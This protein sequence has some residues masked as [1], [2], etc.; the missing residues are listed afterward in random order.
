MGGSVDRQEL[1]SRSGRRG[2][3]AAGA[4]IAVIAVL[5]SGLAAPAW[6]ADDSLPGFVATAE[7][8]GGSVQYGMPGFVVVEQFI[9]GGGPAAKAT[10]SDGVSRSFASNPYPGDNAIGAPGLASL[11]L[12]SAP[13]GYPLYVSAQNPTQPSQAL[14][15]PAGLYSLSAAAKETESAG[16][17]RN[18]SPAADGPTSGTISEAHVTAEGGKIVATAVSFARGIVVGPL[19]VASVESK[20]TTVY[21]S[22]ADKPESTGS[23]VLEGGKVG[24]FTFSFD[25]RGLKVA[26]NGVPLPSGEGLASLNK[27]LAPSGFALSFDSAAPGADGTDA[28][29][30]E[31]MN[32]AA[33]PGAGTG[34]FRLRFGVAKTSIVFGSAGSDGA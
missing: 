28:G 8:R 5:A 33:I 3:W 31:I 17:A 30:F 22:G 18:G 12:G 19:S 6:G 10:M 23:L 2:R 32:V 7:A 25:A 11:F 14:S 15:D 9:D 34:T 21:T 24:D 4:V 1:C 20:S 13:P 16:M 26:Q 29:A 27:A